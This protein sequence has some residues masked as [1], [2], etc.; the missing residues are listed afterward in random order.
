MRRP[1]GAQARRQ[2]SGMPPSGKLPTLLGVPSEPD[3]SGLRTCEAILG[4]AGAR[5]L[6][7]EF[8]GRFVGRASG[9]KQGLD[10]GGLSAS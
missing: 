5:R 2:G 1:L 9:Q 6:W 8:A 3:S 10:S 4:G 7:E